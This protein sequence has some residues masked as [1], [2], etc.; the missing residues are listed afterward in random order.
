MALM[1]PHMPIAINADLPG[2]LMAGGQTFLNQLTLRRTGQLQIKHNR[3]WRPASVVAPSAGTHRPDAHN[4][5]VRSPQQLP[6]NG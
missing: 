4:A 5:K 2:S 3:F 6:D 1:N